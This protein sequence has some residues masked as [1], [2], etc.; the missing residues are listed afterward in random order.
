MNSKRIISGLLALSL[1]FGG[2]LMPNGALKNIAS[3]SASAETVKYGDFICDVL[4]DGTAEISRY[5]G[6]DSEVEIPAEIEGATVTGIGAGAFSGCQTLV[7]VIIPDNVNSIGSAAF[8]SCTK[9]ESITL[10]ANVETISDA[11]FNGCSALKTIEIPD[12]VVS[13]GSVVFNGCVSLE[14]VVL[15]NS[16]ETISDA[17]FIGCSALKEIVIPDSV[18]SIGDSVFSYCTNLENVTLSKGLQSM[19][20]TAFACCDSLNS[21]TMPDGITALGDYTF[22]NCIKLESIVL[23]DSMESIGKSSFSGCTNLNEVNLPEGLALIGETAFRDCVTLK[24]VVI[25]ASVTSIG[26]NAFAEYDKTEKSFK[27]LGNLTLSCYTNSA[28]HKYAS[29]NNLKFEL[30]DAAKPAYPKN[31]KVDY[32]EEYHQIRF[33]WD[34]VENAQ[35]YGIAVYL[36]GKWR[37]QTQKIPYSTVS[38]TTPKNLTPGKTY[39]VA[40][41]AKVDGKWDTSNA[42]KNAVTVTVK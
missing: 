29:Q 7:N 13:V 22:A 3:V 1:V 9:L 26:E 15:S 27:P 23:P 39:K 30:L 19:G 32:S 18:T 11:T 36:A 6:S 25:P 21:V 5:M 14:S 33:T 40:I 8:M 34:K 16:L 20:S 17:A 31:I 4:D 41:A 38:Y 24:S 2:A 42:I 10:S 12:S 37:I 35:Q 28:A